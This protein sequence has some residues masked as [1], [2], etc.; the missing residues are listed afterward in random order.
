M[1]SKFLRVVERCPHCGAPLGAARAD[2]APP[3]VVI[4]LVGHVI[5]AGMLVVEKT[6]APPLWVHMALWIP[7]TIGLSLALIQPVKGATVG[8]LVRLGLVQD[9]ADG[10]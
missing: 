8:L 2:D 5:V 10:R 6:W 4:L 1:F 7:L 3:Y 9:Q